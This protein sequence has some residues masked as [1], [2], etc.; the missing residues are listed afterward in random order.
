MK[1][2]CFGMVRDIPGCLFHFHGKPVHEIIYKSRACIHVSI[3]NLGKVY[4]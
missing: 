4:I 3:N 1:D 2:R